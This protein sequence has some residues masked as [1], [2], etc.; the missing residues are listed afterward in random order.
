MALDLTGPGMYKALLDMVTD[1]RTESLPEGCPTCHY[2]DTEDPDVLQILMARDPFGRKNLIDQARC[3]CVAI[4]RARMAEDE[5]RWANAN[6]PHRQ[7]GNTRTFENFKLRLGTEET[8]RAAEQF[9][10]GT[11][12]RFLVFFGRYGNGKSHLL[13]AVG[14][15]MLQQGSTVR[16]D[17]AKEFLDRL[18]HTYN[19]NSSSEDVFDIL[20]Q[21]TKY[22]VLLLDDVGMES[23]TPWAQEQLT[24]LVEKRLQRQAMTIVATNQG[25]AEMERTLGPRLTS[26]LHA[27]NREMTDV[28]VITNNGSDYRERP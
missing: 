21:Y 9:A 26:R 10:T 16:F 5:D 25:K 14:R 19:Q 6:L 27:T 18:R 24:A 22:P 23:A 2:Y 20:Q 7:Q 13:E 11:G 15:R 3:R 1:R 28:V 4:E 17:L 8:F 12:P